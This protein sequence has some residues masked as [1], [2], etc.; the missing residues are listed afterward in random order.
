MLPV[1]V[2][3]LHVIVNQMK[4]LSVAQQCFCGKIVAGNNQS[5]N[6]KVKFTL[7]Q[8]TK[9]HRG[10]EVSFYPIFNLGARWGGWTT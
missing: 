1:C 4:I 8:A 2:D 3:Q 10:V 6:V 7:E 5:T 9:A